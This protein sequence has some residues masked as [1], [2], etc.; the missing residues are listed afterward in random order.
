M[1]KLLRLT[2]RKKVFL[3]TAA[4]T[5]TLIAVSVTITSVIFSKRK[6]KEAETQCLIYAEILAEYM[7]EY[8][9]Q[10]EAS[11]KTVPFLTY[12]A[13]SLVPIYENNREEIER[14]SSVEVKSEEDL[15]RKKEYFTSLT[16]G[17]FASGMGFGASYAS[18]SFKNAY[19]E[20]IE[21]ME[22]MASLDGVMFCEICI[23]DEAHGNLVFL[24]DSSSEKDET[25]YYPGS[26]EKASAEFIEKVYKRD[27]FAVI[28]SGDELASYVPIKIGGKTVAYATFDYSY[29]RLIDSQKSFVQTLV[30]IMLT[31]TAAMLLLYLLLADRWLVKNVTKLSASARMFTSRMDAGEITPVNAGIKTHDEIM[32]LSDDFYALQNK[33][34]VYSDDIARK[35]AAEERMRAELNIASKIQMQS[36]PDK[37]L[38]TEDFCISSFIKP[39][40]EVGGDL[41]DYFMT[42]DGKL[43]FV[44]ADVTGKGVPA[45]LFMMRGKEIIR[46]SAKAGMS[47]AKI[48]EAANKELCGNNKEGLFITAFIGIYDGRERKLTFSRAGHEQP[49]LLRGGKAEQF[50]EESNFVLGVFD[51]MPYTEDSLEIKE[52]D[53]ILFY[54]DGLNEGINGKNEEFGYERIKEALEAG[55]VDPLYSTYEK[56]TAFAGA[57]EQFDDITMLLFECV[58][59]AAFSLKDPSYNDIPKITDKINEFVKGYDKDKTAEL[60][61][62]IDEVLNNYVSYAFDGVKKPRINID[63]KLENGT[64]RLTFTDNGVLFDPLQIKDPDVEADPLTRPEGGVGIM[65]V[66]TVADKI[67][68]RAADNKNRLTVEKDL[69]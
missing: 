36:L 57:A 33:V 64:V 27:G 34:L 67:T 25:H 61:I 11:G 29:S 19:N 4:L 20:A 47:A 21:E 53:R 44:I 45:A 38:Y 7:S 48:A 28:S 66:K 63:A 9:M 16:S 41:F 8:E 13:D 23:Y 15:E 37:P 32:D 6:Q 59:T 14:M 3:L 60:D 69:N 26:A 5:V 62:I 52:G 17:I 30:P 43:F 39:A 1:K 22:R 55:D 54:T 31:A 18:V 2:I 46:S 24:C 12:Y 49:F 42:D 10:S 50:G 58:K 51:D 68:Y 56:A 35:R 40:K 65:L